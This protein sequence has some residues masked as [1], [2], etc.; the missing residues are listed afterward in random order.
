MENG[1]LN[2]ENPMPQTY[3][4][5]MLYEFTQIVPIPISSK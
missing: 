2:V 1:R 5:W 4:L 3:H